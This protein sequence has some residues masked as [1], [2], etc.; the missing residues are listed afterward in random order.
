MFFDNICENFQDGKV[1]IFFLCIR[2]NVKKDLK[3]Q[4]SNRSKLHLV[5]PNTKMQELD[6]R[7]N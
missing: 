7:V 6:D 3:K 5:V 1:K 4:Y 2:S